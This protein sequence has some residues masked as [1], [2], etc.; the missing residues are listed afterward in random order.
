M[1]TIFTISPDFTTKHLTGWFV[2]NT[3]LQRCLGQGVHLQLFDDFDQCR[4][5]IQA[6]QVDIIYANPSD[7]ALLLRQKGFLP[8]VHPRSRPDEAII[9]VAASSAYQRIED[10]KPGLR[11]ASAFDPEVETICQIMLEP[12]E[13][14][15]AGY[16]LDRKDTYLLV[17]KE[18]MNGDADA[19]FFLAETFK[20]LSP[21]VRGKLRV[22]LQSQIEVVHHM[23][24]LSPRLADKC[25]HLRNKLMTMAQDDKGRAILQDLGIS[26][27]VAT[28]QEE[29]EFM[30]DLMDTL[31]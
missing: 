23:L 2:F 10:F 21:L 31:T 16:S 6:D 15:A 8:L 14:G 11:V 1:S 5:A 19:G 17:A 20:D 30:V 25:E 12:A 13:L 28:E 9:A 24:L 18:L 22:L 29:A 27:W 4:R 7:A 26:Q 3:W